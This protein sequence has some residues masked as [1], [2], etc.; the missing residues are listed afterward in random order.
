MQ[1]AN[2]SPSSEH[3][4]VAFVSSLWNVTVIPVDWVCAGGAPVST[5]T[6]VGCGWN[7]T[8]AGLPIVE[9]LI[10][11]VTWAEP[12]VRPAVRVAEYV[13]SP[14]SLTEPSVPSVLESTT[15]AP[16]PVRPLSFASRAR[17]VMVDVEEPSASIALGEAEMVVW[18][19]AS[20]PTVSSNGALS[21]PAS[22]V[23]CAVSR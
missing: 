10:V 3:A 1:A 4:K 6:L 11:P 19:A 21:A 9:P 13:P 17:T 22:P 20:A 23:D 2:G 7:V 16:P 12:E 5:T 18:P 14:L 8:V 15:V